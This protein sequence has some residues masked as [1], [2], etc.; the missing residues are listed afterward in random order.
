MPSG[1]DVHAGPFADRLQAL[2]DLDGACVVCRACEFLP[3]LY[4]LSVVMHSYRSR[5]V[6]RVL[7]ILPEG[8]KKGLISLLWVVSTTLSMIPHGPL[9]GL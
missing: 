6:A 3:N 8:W 5:G 4:D 7:E 2:K 1:P 9:P